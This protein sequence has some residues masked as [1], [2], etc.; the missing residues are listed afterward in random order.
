MSRR[1][2]LW[3]RWGSLLLALAAFAITAATLFARGG[4]GLSDNGDFYR[5]M[6]ASSLA[7]E[8]TWAS[9]PP[10]REAT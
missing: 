2:A 5:V 4:I 3:R 6:T 1:E 9:R 8:R 10:S 7:P